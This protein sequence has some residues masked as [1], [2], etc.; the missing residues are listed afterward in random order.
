M[1]TLVPSTMTF[2]AKS[3]Q[4]CRSVELCAT[5]TWP[6]EAITSKEKLFWAVMAGETICG[7]PVETWKRDLPS[8]TSQR[9]L[10]Q[11]TLMPEL[12]Y[13]VARAIGCPPTLL[14]NKFEPL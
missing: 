4:C 9:S 5:T 14:R 8:V 11:N 2:V 7:M 13:A 10:C 1:R 6:I 12:G 3:L